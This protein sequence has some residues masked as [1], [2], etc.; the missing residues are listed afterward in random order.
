[1]SGSI[2]LR[3]PAKLNLDLRVLYKR[4]DGYHELRTIFQSISLADR[5]TVRYEPSSD[6]SIA[7]GGNAVI[8]DNLIGRAARLVA[9]ELGTGAALHFTLNKR[10]PMGAGLGGGSSDAAAVLLALPS[11]LGRSLAPERLHQLACS[12]GSDVP[13]FLH[14]GAAAGLGRGDELY[15]LPD[16]PRLPGLLIAPPIHVSTPEAYRALSPRLGD[17]ADRKR[18]EFA[19]VAWTGDLSRA[20]NDFEEAIFEIHPELAVIRDT[21]ERAGAVCARM[22]GSGSSVFG[23]FRDKA[24]VVRAASLLPSYRAL[25]FS[26]LTRARYRALTGRYTA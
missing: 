12:L 20:R 4:A 16:F 25:P 26:L 17:G 15:P 18:L 22:S 2:A 10:I 19:Q 11:L 8:E 23:L 21:L 3:A 13:F 6:L 5:I 14:G 1:M 9:E 24:G 7:I